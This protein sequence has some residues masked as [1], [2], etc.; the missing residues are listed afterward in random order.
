MDW[1]TA[2]L[3]LNHKRIIK[4]SNRP[5][6]SVEEMDRTIIDNI[7][8]VVKNGDTLYVLGDFCFGNPT[9]YYSK[10]LTNFK[11]AY[12]KPIIFIKGSHDKELKKLPNYYMTSCPVAESLILERTF[13]YKGEKVLIVMCHYS[14]RSWNKS[15]YASWHLFGHHHGKL[16]PYGLSF[17]VGID[18]NN[19]FP[20]SLDDVGKKMETLKPI[21][22]FRKTKKGE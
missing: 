18:T 10:L 13:D 5:F 2:D 11:S 20:Y 19:F 6:S 3:H 12:D 17:D 1:F 9:M 21:V 4:Y 8:S 15:H 22:D 16:E 7:N 14:M